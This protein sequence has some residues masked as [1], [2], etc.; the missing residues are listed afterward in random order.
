M[1]TTELNTDRAAAR[2]LG[3]ALGRIGYSERRVSDLLGDDAYDGGREEAPVA[4]RRLPRTPLAAVVRLLFLQLPTPA[5][6]AVEAL[7]RRGVDALGETGLADVGDEIVPR[8]RIL[9]VGNL[10]V[11][12]DDF[13]DDDHDRRPDYVAAYTP[14]SRLLDSLTPRRKVS[15]ALDVGTGSGVQALLS[16][17]HARHVVATDV[18]EHALEYTQLNA[19]LNG[20]DNI[21]CRHGS[22]FDPVDGETFDL[23]T[24]NAPYVVS[25]ESKWAYRDAGFEADELSERVV[26]GAAAHLADDGFA[27]MLISW[28]AH[29]ED[30]PDERPLAWTDGVECDS[31]IVPIWGEDPLGHAATW[32]DH[33]TNDSGRYGAALDSWLEYL[34][35]LGVRWVSEGA[36]ILHRREARTFTARVDEVDEDDLDDAS[37]QVQ[38]AFA[39]RSR[40]TE[41]SR[42]TDLLGFRIA[43][44][45]PVTLEHELEPRRGR[46]TVVTAALTL[47]EGTHSRVEAP[48]RVLELVAALDGTSTL[49]ER[50][51]ASADRLRLSDAETS[52]LR[53]EVLDVC[54]ELL[55][56][57]VLELV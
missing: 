49:E 2:A 11:A 19:A 31:W 8:V 56:L 6:D 51:R 35:R 27:T 28:I 17:R 30:E 33:L 12:S 38:R 42:R 45:A 15:R 29:D 50:L 32:N 57:G 21:E 41:L 13:P 16:A 25:P 40:L 14:T 36:V 37:D 39:A 53:R 18:N 46:T 5:R 24:C 23:V 4:E 48:P 22:L 20:F 9:P 43:V 52:R 7:G 3:E 26:R 1:A 44:A 47:D 54:R 55:E 34:V 10:L